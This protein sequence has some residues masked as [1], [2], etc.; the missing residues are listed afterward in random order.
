MIYTLST[1]ADRSRQ[2][3]ASV[4]IFDPLGGTVVRLPWMPDEIET[5]NTAQ[6]W[7]QLARPGRKPLLMSQGK[8]LQVVTFPARLTHAGQQI[9]VTPTITALEKLARSS[10]ALRLDVAGQ[11][12]GDYRITGLTVTERQ[13]SRDGQITDADVQVELTQT[14]DMAV[15]VGPIKRKTK[16]AK[17]RAILRRLKNVR[18]RGRV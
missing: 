3:S 12:R 9:G 4:R 13:W 11:Y 14:S 10:N 5:S 15:A 18:G 6:A 8:Q 1:T 2:P 7:T 16:A 17:R